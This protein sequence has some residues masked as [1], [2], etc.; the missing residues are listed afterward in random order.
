MIGKKKMEGTYKVKGTT[1]ELTQKGGKS[2]TIWK[3]VAVKDGK[4]I[5][6]PTGKFQNELTRVEEKDKDKKDK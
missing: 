6:P 2:T 3:E 4:L 5:F 1:V